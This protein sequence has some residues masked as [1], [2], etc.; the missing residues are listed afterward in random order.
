MKWTPV[1]KLEPGCGCR[2]EL[3]AHR[4]VR[5]L[6]CGSLTHPLGPSAPSAATALTPRGG[7]RRLVPRATRRPPPPPPPVEDQP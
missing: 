5:T 2:L 6:S 3:A 7:S 1:R 4:W